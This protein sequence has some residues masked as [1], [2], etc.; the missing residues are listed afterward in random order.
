M[1]EWKIQVYVKRPG[2]NPELTK[3]N[4]DLKTLQGIVDGY[5][6]AVTLTSDLVIICNEDG[7]L[8]GLD[9]N[10][11]ILGEDFVG[12]LIFAGKRGSQFASLK[13]VTKNGIRENFPQL[14]EVAE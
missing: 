4:N 11:R 10:C 1:K 9:H 6:E 13:Q 5:I 7:K 12:T 3:I 2:E 8:L 14:W